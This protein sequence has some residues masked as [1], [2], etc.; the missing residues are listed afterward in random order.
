MTWNNATNRVLVIPIAGRSS[1]FAEQGIIGPK[2]AL[3]IGNKSML[4]RSLET[5]LDLAEP[6]QVVIVALSQH[7][8]VLRRILSRLPFQLSVKFVDETPSGQALSVCAGI[9]WTDPNAQL[10]VWNCDSWIEPGRVGRGIWGSNALV[11]ARLPGSHWSFALADDR[12]SVLRTAEKD[13][14]SDWC[15]L[16][17]YSFSSV[18]MY[19]EAVRSVDK[20]RD[21]LYIA[22]L[23]NSLIENGASVNLVPVSASS[24]QVYGTPEEFGAAATIGAWDVP[25][26]WT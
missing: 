19:K 10:I 25:G 8:S 24:F 21:E 20:A 13:R 1:R 22:P 4:E 11:C 23:F 16:G 6:S 14:I 15:S 18:Q 3:E 5:A 17:L 26:R 9:E 7:R 12:M 2:W